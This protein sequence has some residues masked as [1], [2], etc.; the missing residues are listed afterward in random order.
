[1][2]QVVTLL[3]RIL[4]TVILAFSLLGAFALGYAAY[5]TGSSHIYLH[6][7]EQQQVAEKVRSNLE[8]Y[9]AAQEHS[10]AI[11][12]EVYLDVLTTDWIS[13]QMETLTE[14][15]YAGFRGANTRPAQSD[16]DFSAL[17]SSITNYFETYADSISYPK[18]DT[19]TEKL[20]EAISAAESKIYK[21]LD[22]FQFE[23]M[24]KSGLFEK[25]IKLHRLSIYGTVGAAVVSVA[26][27]CVL[28][29][30]ARRQRTY[31]MGCTLLAGGLMMAAPF[32]YLLGSQYFQRFSIK[33]PAI[34]SFFTGVME[35][36]SLVCMITG[37]I[38]AGMGLLGICIGIIK[39]RRNA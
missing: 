30:L 23:T 7:L 33:D 10:T 29:L 36:G 31:W 12:K 2:K 24:E 14:A 34:F 26:C 13:T 21:Q 38:G 5:A 18:D 11:P 1:M 6:Q 4:C 19:Y 37:L 16:V 15:G 3:F 35:H 22:V 20:N 28:L 32:G 27:L 39:S 9:Y 17:E 8:T 25:V